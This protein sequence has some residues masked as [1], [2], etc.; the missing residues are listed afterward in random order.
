MKPFYETVVLLY[1]KFVTK[2]L[3]VF[4]FKSQALSS[5]SFLDPVQ[6]Q[7]KSPSAFDKVEGMYI[8]RF[9]GINLL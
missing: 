1:E 4:N 7:Y 8:H 5:L 6:K 3:K 9:F 2:L